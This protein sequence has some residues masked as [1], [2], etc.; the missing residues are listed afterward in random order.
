M[1]AL[2]KPTNTSIFGQ[3]YNL[4]TNRLEIINALYSLYRNT[5]TVLLWQKR[6]EDN[7]V[8]RA[9]FINV[10]DLKNKNFSTS[11]LKQKDYQNFKREHNIY[12]R[13][14][15][16]G[17][18]F[19]ENQ[20]R[21]SKGHVTIPFPEEIHLFSN[22]IASR[23]HVGFRVRSF[24]EVMRSTGDQTIFGRTPMLLQIF[25]ISPGGISFLLDENHVKG[26][27]QGDRLFIKRT[28]NRLLDFELYGKVRYLQKINF[29]H[30]QKDHNFWK[31]GVA[32][33]DLLQDEQWDYLKSLIL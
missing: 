4:L 20:F 1:T 33:D 25:D 32:F 21:L 23:T 2:T 22:R 11:P 12:F 15:D 10:L 5:S 8:A 16:K 24:A 28:N 29:I 9:S 6:S 27:F 31:V 19:K 7:R 18:V 26:L 3:S 30:D 14:K 13:S 17:V